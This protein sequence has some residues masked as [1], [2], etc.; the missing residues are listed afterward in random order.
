MAGHVGHVP[1][2]SE[3]HCGTGGWTNETSRSP[4]ATG[5]GWPRGL[6]FREQRET[7]GERESESG[8][9]GETGRRGKA[10]RWIQK[11][12]SETEPT[13]MRQQDRDLRGGEETPGD[14]APES[15]RR[16]LRHR[17]EVT[18]MAGGSQLLQTESRL[19]CSVSDPCRGETR[20]V[21]IPPAPGGPG[22]GAGSHS[23]G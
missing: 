8:K 22:Q 14:K 20:L 13:E 2:I 7:P 23:P 19:R 10:E 17:Q 18:C 6:M 5:K 21:L 1:I 15:N 11:G 16:E 4:G 9:H 12:N 3:G